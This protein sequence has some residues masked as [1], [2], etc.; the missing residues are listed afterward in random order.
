MKW[1]SNWPEPEYLEQVGAVIWSVA[2]IEWLAFEVIRLLDPRVSLEDLAG[3]PGGPIARALAQTAETA[4][5]DSGVDPA[6]AEEAAMLVA[7]LT[8]LVE[9]RTTSFTHGPHGLERS[10]TALPLG[11]H[12][13]ARQGRGH[14]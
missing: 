8:G 13:V 6:L 1:P 14:R 2:S 7:N 10:A 5:G 11:T 4:R 9:L 3:L 12:E